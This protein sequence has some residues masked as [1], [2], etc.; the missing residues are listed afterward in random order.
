MKGKNVY[1]REFKIDD[2]HDVH[3]YASLERVCRYQTWGPNN[4]K[5]HKTM[6]NK[7]LPM[8]ANVLGRGLHLQLL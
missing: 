4:E 7:R 5:I 3:A 6:L 1:L 8:L 2:W